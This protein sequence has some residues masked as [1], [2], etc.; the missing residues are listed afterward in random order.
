MEDL[1]MITHQMVNISLNDW[2]TSGP[3]GPYGPIDTE[4]GE[5]RNHKR[6]GQYFVMLHEVHLRW[7][8]N[9]ITDSIFHEPN[10]QVALNKINSLISNP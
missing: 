2:T 6:F 8:C 4:K 7:I 1:E 3:I 9:N 10:T 5:Y